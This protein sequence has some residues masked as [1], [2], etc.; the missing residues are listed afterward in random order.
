M[1]YN[2]DYGQIL[3]SWEP[4]PSLLSQPVNNGKLKEPPSVDDVRQGAQF[5]ILPFSASSSTALQ[6]LLARYLDFIIDNPAVSLSDISLTLQRSRSLLS[7]RSFVCGSD[8]E[9]LITRLTKLLHEMPHGITQ[10]KG[11]RLQNIEPEAASSILGIFTGQGAQWPSMSRELLLTSKQFSSTISALD[12]VL[13]G[14]SDGPQWTLREE[15]LAQNESSRCY[16]AA[17][18]QPLCTAV[19]IALVDL[20]RSIGVRFSAVVGHSSGEIA[21]V[22]IAVSF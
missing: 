8:R 18:A 17:L 5:I 1:I 9:E 10:A 16:D 7:Y 20:L 11:L 6:A 19:Q 21:A 14:L 12:S 4:T 13:K 2:T 3:E 15:L 22:S